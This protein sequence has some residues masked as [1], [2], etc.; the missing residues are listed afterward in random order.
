MGSSHSR[1]SKGSKARRRDRLDPL[2]DQK[3]R[4][5]DDHGIE[6]LPELPSV[7][8]KPRQRALD[9]ARKCD[10]CGNEDPRIVS[11]RD[12]VRAYCVCG[13]NWGISLSA[14]SPNLPL[15]SGRGISKQTLVEPD[16]TLADEDLDSEEHFVR[17]KDKDET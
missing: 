1:G 4:F 7:E 5:A 2:T 13:F 8:V 10:K 16:W 15:N 3:K 17:T 14:V 12:G 11:N 9:T 6:D